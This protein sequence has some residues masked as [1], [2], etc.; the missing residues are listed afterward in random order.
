[1]SGQTAAVCMEYLQFIP[2]RTR[3]H[4]MS[5]DQQLDRTRSAQLEDWIDRTGKGE[6]DAFCSLYVQTKRILFSYAL[7]ILHNRED[8]EDAVQDT[9]LRI[10]SASHLYTPLGKPLAWMFTIERNVCLMRLRAKSRFSDRPLE[11]GNGTDREDGPRGVIISGSNV[12]PHRPVGVRD[13]GGGFTS[14]DAPGTCLRTKDV[15]DRL[16]L[17]RALQTLSTEESSIVLL[18]AA[19]GVKHREIADQLGI[20]LS[21]VLSKYRRALEK[22]RRQFSGTGS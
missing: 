15:E 14:D 11:D 22:L 2:C 16:V 8:A 4:N 3:E 19:A 1:M 7:S 13:P 20:P 17:S 12:S 9:Y 18:H 6:K 21:T 10:R 5:L